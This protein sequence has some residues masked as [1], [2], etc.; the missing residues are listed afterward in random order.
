MNTVRILI[1][2]AFTSTI[3]I[4]AQ[5]PNILWQ[6][7]YYDTDSND[8][9]LEKIVQTTDLGYIIAGARIQYSGGGGWNARITKLH[10]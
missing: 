8:N 9:V 4:Y 5:D 6:K 3:S 10:F 7:S 2:L 1:I